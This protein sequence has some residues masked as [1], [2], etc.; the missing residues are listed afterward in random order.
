MLN[1]TAIAAATVL[2]LWASNSMAAVFDVSVWTGA[3]NGADS[4]NIADRF[5]VPTLAADAHFTFTTPDNAINWS[6]TTNVASSFFTGGTISG[7]TSPEGTL[8]QTQFNNE[9]LSTAG[10]GTVS[11]IQVTSSYTSAT[12]FSSTITHDDGASMYIDATTAILSSPGETSSITQ[13]YILP[14]GSHTLTVDYV[15]A[16]GAPAVLSYIAAV[17]E[18]ST[19]A[20]MILGFVGV[21]FMSYRRRSNGGFRVA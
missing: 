14:A 8:T 2:S 21:G 3:P 4:S 20:M 16:Q 19:W 18:P 5:N 10:D 11:F 9:I 6:S 1:K 17:P 15:E 7:F 12:P 13:P